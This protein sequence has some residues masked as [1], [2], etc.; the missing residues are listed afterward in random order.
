MAL[1]CCSA[2]HPIRCCQT[3]K[4]VFIGMLNKPRTRFTF[5][6]CTFQNPPSPN[7]RLSKSYRIGDIKA[8]A[9]ASHKTHACISLKQRGNSRNNGLVWVLSD[10]ATPISKCHDHINLWSADLEPLNESGTA[11]LFISLSVLKMSFMIEV[12]V[13]LTVITDK[14]LERGCCFK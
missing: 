9:Q 10:K 13:Y 4:L 3:Y 11:F 6:I 12:V 8:S 2:T 7:E 1:N 14:P 5:N